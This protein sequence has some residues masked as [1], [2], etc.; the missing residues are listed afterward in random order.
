MLNGYDV[1]IEHSHWKCMRASLSIM[2]IR[3]IFMIF[4]KIFMGVFMVWL[5]CK[6]EFNN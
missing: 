3:G 1:A 6:D 2:P 5:V 4:Y